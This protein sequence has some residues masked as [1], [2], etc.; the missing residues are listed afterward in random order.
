MLLKLTIT[1]VIIALVA[2]FIWA[3]DDFDDQDIP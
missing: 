3:S 2:L 1:V